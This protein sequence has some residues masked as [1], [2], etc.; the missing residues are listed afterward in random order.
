[1]IRI[2]HNEREIMDRS[3][4][5]KQTVD[6]YANV[7]YR[8][9]FIILKN[10]EDVEDVLQDTFC[11][12]WTMEK[13]FDFRVIDNGI[14]LDIKKKVYLFI[15]SK[16]SFDVVILFDNEQG[17]YYN[18]YDENDDIIDIVGKKMF[19]QA[20]KYTILQYGV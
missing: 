3:E 20:R 18:S 8:I 12:Y 9:C 5:F 7:L 17:T 14:A 15:T 2:K 6:K 19:F 1:M 16:F 13:E 10:K 4:E 11:K